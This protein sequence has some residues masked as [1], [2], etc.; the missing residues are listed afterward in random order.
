MDGIGEM[1]WDDQVGFRRE[2]EVE[3]GNTR[4]VSYS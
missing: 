2:V 1:E 3:E 4:R